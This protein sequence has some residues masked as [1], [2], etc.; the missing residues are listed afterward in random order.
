MEAAAAALPPKKAK[1]D[2][3][4]ASA[5]TSGMHYAGT[6]AADDFDFADE[7]SNSDSE[8]G[9][10]EEDFVR[11]DTAAA[12][13]E[14]RR[15]F[16]AW[17]KYDVDWKGLFPGAKLEGDNGSFD[18][19]GDL[20]DLDMGRLYERIITTVDQSRAMLGFLPDMAGCSD[21]QIDALN[22]ESFAER[23]ISGANLVMTDGNTLLG[24]KELEMLVVLR[25]NRELMEFMRREY[26][27]E[28]K[29]TQPYN[30]T[31]VEDECKTR[32][33]F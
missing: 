5:L 13:K 21:G 6:D 28:I 2:G 33:E 4:A 14:F 31:V 20:I 10:S 23:A 17:Y 8:P 3:A 7:E 26:A 16:P 18:L 1:T 15:V 11:E 9:K 25:M 30:M 24:D 22:A 29:L 32:L 27:D 19:L 12:E